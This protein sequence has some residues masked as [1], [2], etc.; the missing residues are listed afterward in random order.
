[1]YKKQNSVFNITI[2]EGL[3]SVLRIGSAHNKG[4]PLNINIVQISHFSNPFLIETVTFI[5]KRS[6]PEKCQISFSKSYF[7]NIEFQNVNKAFVYITDCNPS[8]ISISSKLSLFSTRL[9][10][11]RQSTII[12]TQNNQKII[13]T[14]G[15]LCDLHF[16]STK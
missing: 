2:K 16:A 3:Q 9:L 6:K 7:T 13:Q 4:G 14:F 8:L 11:W 1:M 5:Y 15:Y 12:K 10:K